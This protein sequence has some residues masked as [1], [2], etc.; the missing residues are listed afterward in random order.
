MNVV[1][2]GTCKA[3]DDLPDYVK[4]NPV[5]KVI[6][7]EPMV[8]HHEDIRR[9]YAGTPYIIENCAIVVNDLKEMSF[10]YHNHDGPKFE[11]ASVSR[12]HILKHGYSNDENLVE[13]SVPCM[14]I[15]DL[16]QKHNL[17]KIDYLFIDS[18]GL[19]E[20]LIKDIDFE[21][22]EIDQIYFEAL[23]IDVNST[24]DYL[25]NKG[26]STQAGVGIY[27]WDCLSTRINK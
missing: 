9:E 5:T 11:V 3:N 7:V 21:K 1:Q 20:V 13:L 17:K 22:Y 25:A 23:H 24:I 16:F 2:I 27:G 4:S 8:V 18:E 15:N 26:Y 12:E 14:R 19:D 10:F 6:L